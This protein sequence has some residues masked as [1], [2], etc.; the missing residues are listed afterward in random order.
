MK[1]SVSRSVLCITLNT[2]YKPHVV[3]I[4]EKSA[5]RSKVTSQSEMKSSFA[6]SLFFF[7]LSLSLSGLSF[8]LMFLWEF[9]F[10]S[11]LLK[12]SLSACIFVSVEKH[13]TIHLTKLQKRN[14]CSLFDTTL[15][16]VPCFT[17]TAEAAG[18]KDVFCRHSGVDLTSQ[19]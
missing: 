6:L 10:S 11:D 8:N 4:T 1:T 2:F 19:G 7:F 17:V 5:N 9:S 3:N 15:S 14:H 12:D 13:T 18:E 16:N